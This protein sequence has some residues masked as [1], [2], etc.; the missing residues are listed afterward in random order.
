MGSRMDNAHYDMIVLGSGAAGLSSAVTAAKNGL[1][2]LVIEK[3]KDIGGTT[4]WS[5]GWIWSPRNLFATARGI[6]HEPSEVRE[7]LKNVTG[8]FF[9]EKRVDAFIEN[10]PKMIDFFHKNTSLQFQGD[11]GIPDTYGH[12]PGAGMGGRS[13][14]AEPFDA[15]MLGRD[16]AKL[17]KPLNETTFYGLMI[18]S[19]SDLKAFMSMTRSFKSMVHVGKRMTRFFFDMLRFRRSTDLR[20]GN[21]LIGRLLKSAIDLGV[22]FKL[23]AQVTALVQQSDRV[24]GVKLGEQEILANKGVVLASGGYPHDQQRREKLF[25]RNA[26]HSTLATSL[27]TG[28]GASLAESVGGHFKSDTAAPAAYCPVSLVPWQNGRIGVFPH[29]IDRGKP[30]LIAVRRNGQRFCNEGLGYHDFVAD[31][32]AQLDADEPAKAWMICDY[33]FLRRYGL[34]IVRP[35]PVPYS[36]WVKSGYLKEANTLEELARQC[37]IDSAAFVQTVKSFNDS[38][39][40]GEDPEFARG[41]TPYMRLQGDAEIQP[42]PC[43]APILKAPFF[44]IEVV[45]GSFG[46]F[47]GI[48]VD[49]NCR[50]L[51][52]DQKPIEGLFAVGTDAASVF[53]GFYPAGGIAI[54]PALTFGYV[55]GNYVAGTTNE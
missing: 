12:Q 29:I 5:G 17:K 13:A 53:G 1:R 7:Y 4:A 36:P 16:F 6:H 18:Q 19:G 15:K 33:R 21:A 52:A 23:E 10:A 31:L 24:V 37:G 22:E 55:V 2:V 30:G 47:A 3:D 41:T 48:D 43:V 11:P 46:T 34:G 28:D 45:P 26:E 25:V 14:I 9:N 35:T 39:A 42:N 54:G 40:K 32:Q 51:T 8:P 44:A 20:N 38:A 27:A 50:V 49:E